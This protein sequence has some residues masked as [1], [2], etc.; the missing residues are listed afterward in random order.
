MTNNLKESSSSSPIIKCRVKHCYRLYQFKMQ[1]CGKDMKVTVMELLSRKCLTAGMKEGID[2]H[3][4]SLGEETGKSGI[5][6]G[7][8]LSAQGWALP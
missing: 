3:P 6:W 8:N 2:I 5:N 4:Y 1:S 7:K